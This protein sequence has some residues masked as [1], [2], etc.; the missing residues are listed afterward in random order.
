M[1]SRDVALPSPAPLVI[2]AVLAFI[3]HVAGGA[4]L[5]RSHASSALG[6]VED[7]MRCPAK[8]MPAE[9]SLPYD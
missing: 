6:A 9:P 4:A 8:A 5:D 2:V 1:N 3:L 7:G